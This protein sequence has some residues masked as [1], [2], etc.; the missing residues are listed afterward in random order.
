MSALQGL[1][2]QIVACAGNQDL[3]QCG[4][5]VDCVHPQPGDVADP[6][7]VGVGDQPVLGGAARLE[8]VLGAG[9]DH[10]SVGQNDQPVAE[11]VDQIEL[12][13][14]EQHGHP[15]GGPLGE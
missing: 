14:A 12:M 1:G 15:T 11:P 13:A 8:V 3:E 6:P 10:A 2:E 4:A 9:G 5:A 7:G